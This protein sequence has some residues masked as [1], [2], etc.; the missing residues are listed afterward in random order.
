VYSHIPSLAH[1]R[2]EA[3]KRETDFNKI[4]ELAKYGADELLALR[5]LKENI[6][7]NAVRGIERLPKP[8]LF[9]HSIFVLAVPAGEE[10]NP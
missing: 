8:P 7:M 4:R 2:F 10:A 1:Q 9:S 3:H 5:R 6:H